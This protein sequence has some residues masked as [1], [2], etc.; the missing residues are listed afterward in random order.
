MLKIYFLYS[1]IACLMV[2]DGYYLL[3][4]SHW[5][6]EGNRLGLGSLNV[7]RNGEAISFVAL[8]QE[9]RS[10]AAVAKGESGTAVALKGFLSSP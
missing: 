10:E 1:L 9:A 2:F 3:C 5:G 7:N 8:W 6:T 4:M